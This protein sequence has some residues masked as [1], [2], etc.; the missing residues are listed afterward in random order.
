MLETAMPHAAESKQGMLSQAITQMMMGY[1]VSQSLY[2]VTKLGIPDLLAN[3][4]ENVTELA[5]KSGSYEDYL[6]RILRMLAKTGVFKQLPDRTFQLTDMGHLLRSDVSNSMR[7]MILMTGSEHYQA[8]GALF[9]CVKTGKRPFETVY[10]MNVF[11]YFEKH[12]EAGEL[13]NDAMSSLVRN[14]HSAVIEH[15]DFSPFNTL[16]DI[17]GGHGLLLS[18]ILTRYPNLKGILF[19]LPHVVKGAT[20]TFEQ[21]GIT[22]RCEIQSGDFFKAVAAGGDVYIMS[23]IIHDWNDEA[24][25]TLLKNTH[26]AMTDNGK[27]LLVETVIQGENAPIAGE[28]MDLNMLVMTPGGRER[29]EE[30]YRTLLEK[31]GF[32]LERIIPTDCNHSII[33]S[34]KI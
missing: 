34:V 8:W 11:E 1:F 19:D 33:E 5:Q 24:C 25:I 2:T 23:H 31:A 17:G 30:E 6:Y 12:P 18:M 10:G 29:T 26:Q 15:Y 28:M 22:D 20:D 27:L 7:P 14:S 16:V 4:P 3:G 21:A 13:F 32:R 9:D